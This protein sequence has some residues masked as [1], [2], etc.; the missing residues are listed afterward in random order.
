MMKAVETI[1]KPSGSP[2]ARLAAGVNLER[3]NGS[4]MSGLGAYKEEIVA[5]LRSGSPKNFVAKPYIVSEPTLYNF[6]EKH[7]LDVEPGLEE[8]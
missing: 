2:A 5:L 1:S 7:L 4:G 8:I 3:K 6:I